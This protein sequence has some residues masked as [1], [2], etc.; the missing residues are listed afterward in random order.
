MRIFKIASALLLS[1]VLTTGFARVAR[2][3]V[4]PVPPQDPQQMALDLKKAGEAADRHRADLMKIPHVTGVVAET[5]NENEAGLLV[6]IDNPENTDDVT[7]GLPSQIEGFPVQVDV[8]VADDPEDDDSDDKDDDSDTVKP[9]ASA[10]SL[11]G[12]GIVAHD[13]GAKASPASASKPGDA[14]H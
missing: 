3:Q 8:S 7:R 11:A 10:H 13:A 14:K 1:I 5:N 12:G 9:R 6:E 2:A 4:P